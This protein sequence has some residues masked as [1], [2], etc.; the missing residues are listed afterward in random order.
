M[1]LISPSKPIIFS[2]ILLSN[3]FNTETDKTIAIEPTAI[4]IIA[5]RPVILVGPASFLV[6]IKFLAILLEKFIR[7]SMLVMAR[8]LLNASLAR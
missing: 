3:P 2:T 8:F 4:P 1:S 5:I 7:T 6:N